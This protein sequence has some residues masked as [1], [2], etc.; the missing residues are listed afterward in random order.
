[1]IRL[2]T[3]TAIRY[4]DIV[5]CNTKAAEHI[6]NPGIVF[7]TLYSTYLSF[8]QCMKFATKTTMLTASLDDVMLATQQGSITHVPTLAYNISA[9]K[10]WAQ[11]MKVPFNEKVQGS[12]KFFGFS[13]VVFIVGLA[14]FYVTFNNGASK[15]SFKEPLVRN[16]NMVQV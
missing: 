16:T 8:L 11:Q 12:P 4:D 1:M 9:P 13:L 7:L 6:L 14:L 2:V 15:S 5:Y 10:V 3:P